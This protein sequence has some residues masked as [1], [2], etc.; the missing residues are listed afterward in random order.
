MR[1]WGII[2]AIPVSRIQVEATPRMSVPMD[3][4]TTSTRLIP[5]VTIIVMARK[6]RS[7]TG[8]MITAIV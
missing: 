7:Q 1:S 4:L 5:T 8:I 3:I 2:M 6:I